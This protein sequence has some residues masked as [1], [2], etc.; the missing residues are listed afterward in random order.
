[1]KRQLFEIQSQLGIKYVYGCSF[2]LFF[3]I[4]QNRLN[5]DFEK[6]PFM[7]TSI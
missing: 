1:M 7:L 2:I 3:I 6:V 4:L 5:D